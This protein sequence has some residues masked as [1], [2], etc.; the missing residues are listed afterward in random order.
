MQPQV[1]TAMRPNQIFR[2]IAALMV[3]GLPLLASSHGYR[4][5]DIVIRH[6]WAMPTQTTTGFGY[7]MLRNTGTSGD[8]LLSASTI[9]AARTDLRAVAEAGHDAPTKPVDALAIPAGQE[10]RL[11]PGGP[12]LQFSGLKSLLTDGDRLSLTLRFQHA[13]EI[14]V[15]MFVQLDA[16]SAIY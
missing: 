8:R 16:K 11:E 2:Q 12:H 5:G 6:P 9:S 14:T 4:L 3:L 7:L 15:D 13:G 1:I 10:I